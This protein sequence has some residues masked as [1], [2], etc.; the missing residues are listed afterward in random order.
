MVTCT[1]GSAERIFQ[2]S[3]ERWGDLAQS[4]QCTP[5]RGA[6]I[7]SCMFYHP[8]CAHSQE[9]ES[10]EQCLFLLAAGEKPL[11]PAHI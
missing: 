7:P 4:G 3:P 9:M 6:I 1:G 8:G 2:S 10:T 5:G 11:V